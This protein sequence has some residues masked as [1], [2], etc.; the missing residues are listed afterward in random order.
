MAKLIL[1]KREEVYD[2]VNRSFALLFVLL[3]DRKK[4]QQQ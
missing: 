1:M 2:I 4:Q 3:F